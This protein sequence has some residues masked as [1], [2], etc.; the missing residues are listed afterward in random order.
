MTYIEYYKCCSCS[1]VWS[2]LYSTE[3]EDHSSLECP[4]CACTNKE[5]ISELDYVD[6]KLKPNSLDKYYTDKCP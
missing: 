4:S 2:H 5:E 6:H 1:G 3:Y